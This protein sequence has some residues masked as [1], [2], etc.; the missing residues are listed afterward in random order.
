MDFDTPPALGPLYARALLD[1]RPPRMPEGRETPRLE[2]RLA[3]QAIDEA[4]LSR[5]RSVCGFAPSEA[6][7]I[8][9]PHVLAAG[10]QMRM[11]TE[12]TFPVRI[13][14]LIHVSHVIRQRRPIPGDARPGIHCWLEG[15]QTTEAGEAFCLNATAELDGEICWEEETHF[16]ARSARRGRG[17]PPRPADGAS[18][19]LD[20][21]DAPADIG[22]RYARVS[23]DYNPIHLW[24]WS[25]RLFG[26]PGAIAH[27]MWSLARCAA[28]LAPRT[29]GPCTLMAR[30]LRPL[31]LPAT[32]ELRGAEEASATTFQLIDPLDGTVYLGGSA[33]GP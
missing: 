18:T 28:A 17:S 30:F 19:P 15:S 3:P 5:Y 27:G 9:Y 1:R 21:W 13:A 6:V 7:P 31:V 29:A 25:A 32:V 14:G 10:L 24:P 33:G 2:G 23:G 8:T 26:F 11:L 12:P 4:R 22:R 16:I 20:R